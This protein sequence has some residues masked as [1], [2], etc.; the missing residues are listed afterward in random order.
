MGPR[1]PISEKLAL[2]H[3]HTH[4]IT[5]NGSVLPTKFWVEVLPPLGSH[6]EDSVSRGREEDEGGESCVA[7]G[8]SQ[9]RPKPT[10]SSPGG[11]PQAGH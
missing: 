9:Q 8:A 6:P 2:L 11:N 10:W 1:N 7:Q 4:T 5:M 3:S